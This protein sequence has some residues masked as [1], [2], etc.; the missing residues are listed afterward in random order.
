M[1]LEK[2][3]LDCCMVLLNSYILG[4]ES[5]KGTSLPQT[6]FVQHVEEIKI[7][8]KH[9]DIPVKYLGEFMLIKKKVSR[10]AI[11][12]IG[13]ATYHKVLQLA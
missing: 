10:M 12:G 7:K 8:T 5:F 4:F 13:C 3:Q 6:R 11:S 2:V 9:E 1:Q